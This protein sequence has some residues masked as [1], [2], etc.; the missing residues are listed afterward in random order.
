MSGFS[1]GKPL[2][3]GASGGVDGGGATDGDMMHWDDDT[4]SLVPLEITEEFDVLVTQPTILHKSGLT[5][6]IS[7]ASAT[8]SLLFRN[9]RW[10]QI[11]RYRYYSL[12]FRCNLDS[13]WTFEVDGADDVFDVF[14][15]CGV[16][17]LNINTG[18]SGTNEI[19]IQRHSATNSTTSFFCHFMAV[20]SV[21]EPA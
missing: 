7:T 6:T 19:T 15:T 10:T 14:V 1:F 4:Q 2:G 21:P 18:K 3:G 13:S 5:W 16:G 8:S 12:E 11:G 17:A 9:A 20:M